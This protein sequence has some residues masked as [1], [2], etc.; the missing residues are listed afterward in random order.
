MKDSHL[1][2]HHIRLLNGR[3]FQKLLS[4][5]PEALIVVNRA[6]FYRF[7]GIVKLAAQLRQILLWRL[8]LL[9]IH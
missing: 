8:D 7:Y 5:D 9:T 1:V 3:I 4:Q 2:A 6:R